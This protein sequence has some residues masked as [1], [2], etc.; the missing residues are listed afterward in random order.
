MVISLKLSPVLTAAADR[1]VLWGFLSFWWTVERAYHGSLKYPTLARSED[2]TAET[3][4]RRV[5]SLLECCC[6]T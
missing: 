3:S 2:H 5:K 6:I 4:I 1:A